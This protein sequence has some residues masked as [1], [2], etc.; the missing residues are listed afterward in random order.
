M[1]CNVS[2]TP[3]KYGYVLKDS[4]ELKGNLLD[5]IENSSKTEVL[6]YEEDPTSLFLS[7]GVSFFMLR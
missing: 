7:L 1:E 2:F 3:N 4:D 6:K 5:I